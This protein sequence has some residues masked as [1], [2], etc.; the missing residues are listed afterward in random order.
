MRAAGLSSDK[1][2]ADAKTG[3][4]ARACVCLPLF[5]LTCYHCRVAA[6]ERRGQ[7]TS[8]NNNSAIVR[9]RGVNEM[10]AKTHAVLLQAL[11]QGVF[12][13]AP[14]FVLMCV[15]ALFSSRRNAAMQ[16]Q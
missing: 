13:C 8:D 1:E 14:L 5:V 15:V 9:A 3:V 7:G 2:K 11:P 4:R 6:A 12:L 10:E 16:R